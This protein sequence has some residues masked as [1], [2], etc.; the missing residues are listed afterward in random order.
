MTLIRDEKELKQLYSNTS[1]SFDRTSGVLKSKGFYK[2]FIEAASANVDMVDEVN[3]I[4]KLTVLQ[5]MRDG[6][7]SPEN[8]Q[9][10]HQ[11]PSYPV[12]RL[13]VLLELF[14]RWGLLY[15]RYRQSR[16]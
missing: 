16:N 9:S 5:A 13:V 15:P 10:I 1:H 7:F 12:P 11:P 6:D 4:S 14:V 2:D 3:S 8:L